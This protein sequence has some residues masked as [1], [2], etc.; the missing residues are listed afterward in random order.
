MI[1]GTYRRQRRE[2]G[3][4]TSPDMQQ[5]LEPVGRPVRPMTA[6]GSMTLNRD[7]VVRV[8]TRLRAAAPGPNPR[9]RRGI[10]LGQFNASIADSGLAAPGSGRLLPARGLASTAG[11]RRG[12]RVRELERRSAWE[13]AERN[14]LDNARSRPSGS[15]G[16]L[17]S[18]RLRSEGKVAGLHGTTSRRSYDRPQVAWAGRRALGVSR[19]TFN[20]G[21]NSPPSPANAR[22]ASRT[23]G[24][25]VPRMSNRRGGPTKAITCRRSERTMTDPGRGLSKR[26]DQRAPQYTKRAGGPRRPTVRT[27]RPNRRT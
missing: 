22:P 8:A 9:T 4:A 16:G 1:L 23:H 13:P 7:P 11:S 24:R 3:L 26:R 21:G 5:P 20:R 6:D 12:A 25:R 27:H 19:A 2:V 15:P 18:H 17:H 10:K 14:P